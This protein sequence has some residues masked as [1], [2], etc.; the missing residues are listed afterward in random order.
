M[1]T[2]VHVESI[3]ALGIRLNTPEW[4]EW[5]SFQS[6]F[7]Y[8]GNSTEMSV[9]RR[10]SNGKWYA[11]KKVYSSDKGSIPVDLYIGA[12]E[13][14]TSERLKEI[15]YRFGQNWRDFWPWYHS[16]ARKESKAK[17]VQVY[18]EPPQSSQT[19]DENE[20]LKAPPDNFKETTLLRECLESYQQ[21]KHVVEAYRNETEELRARL[22]EVEAQLKKKDSELAEATNKIEVLEKESR[23]L[24][25]RCSD[26]EREKV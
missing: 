14:C 9:K 21:Q 3:P 16:P 17:G 25:Y 11:R 20:K 7:K 22:V 6:Q 23:D 10:A 18:T 8:I 26:L 15:N 12:N 19:Q 1:T 2:D 4:F 24:R 5:V 13:E